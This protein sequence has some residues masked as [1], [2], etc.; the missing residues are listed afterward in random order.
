MQSDHSKIARLEGLAALSGIMIAL[1]SRANGEL[2]HR[3]D[4][5]IQAAFVS[6]SSGLIVLLVIAAFSAQV[7]K[8]MGNL[9]EAL[10]DGRIPWWQV[11]AGVLGGLFVALQTQ[12][13]PLI[14]V[15]IYSVASIAGQTA[16][17][18][19]VDR[20]GLTGGGKKLISKRRVAAAV[21]TVAA[22]VVSVLDK[23]N[24]STFS[25]FAVFLSLTA[26]AMVGVQRALN[27]QINEHT[28]VSFSTSL[29]NFIMG[30]TT[31]SIIWLLGVLF[32]HGKISPLPGWN[33]LLY[34][35]GTI[36]V[37]YIAFTATIVQHLGVLTF[38]LFSVGGTL[39]GSLL[40]DLFI[41]S[42]GV[43]VSWYLV[44]GI[45]MT[46]IGVIIGGQSRIFKR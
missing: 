33:L 45:A 31:L 27:G 42:H 21:V 3:L 26:G 23:F 34:T 36:G 14:G 16:V 15:A 17:S 5:S 6:F 9:K 25:L 29:L 38:T 7:R 40:I 13:V 22:V 12:V 20:I 39:I 2:S 19:F 28:K 18:L 1:Q 4:N 11:P 32:A 8:G 41:P 46:Y 10:K 35:G 24:V 37:I 30:T 44:S 43:G